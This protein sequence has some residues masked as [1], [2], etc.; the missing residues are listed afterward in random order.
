M[1]DKVSVVEKSGS[2]PK[3][4]K[5]RKSAADHVLPGVTNP[6]GKSA[7]GRFIEHRDDTTIVPT[8]D[9]YTRVTEVEVE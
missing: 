8:S 3:V 7:L 6:D 2:T 9:G 4:F 5:D 1:A